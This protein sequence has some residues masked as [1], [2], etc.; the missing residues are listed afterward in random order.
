HACHGR[1]RQVEV[2]RDAIL[3]LLAED[4]TLEPRDVIVMCPDVEAFAPLVHATFGAG[5]VV[6]DDEAAPSGDR[7]PDLRVRLADRSLRQTNPVLGVVA[8]LL[9]LADQR[10]TASQVL[11]LADREPVRRRFRFDDDEIARIEDWVADSGIRWGLDAPHRA[12]FKLDALDAGTWRAG[13]DRILVGVAMAE[14]GPRRFGPVLPLDDV[15]SGA[16]ELAGRL[17]ELLDRLRGAVDALSV[18]MPVAGWAEAIGAAADALCAAPPRETWQRAQLER[19]LDDAVREAAGST[20]PLALPEIRSLLADRLQGRP[21][22]ANF[23][24]GHLTVCT[25][26]PMRSVPHRVVCLLGLDDGAFPR[27]TA[28]DGDDLV[29]D[30]PRL[31]DRDPR[32]EDRQMLLDALLAASDRLVVTYSGRDERTNTPRPPAVPVGE[33]L[34]MVDATVRVPGDG[35]RARDQVVVEHPLQPFDR[36]SFEPGRL[37]PG[38]PWSFDRVMLAGARALEGERAPARPFLAGP[39]PAEAA[40]LVALEDLVRFAEHPVKAF[41]RGRLG[42]RVGRRDDETEDALPVQLDGLQEW[43]VGRRLLEARLAGTP[44]DAGVEAEIARGTLPPG[45]L[46]LPVIEKVRPVVEAIAAQAEA[47]LGPPGDPDP[48]DVR[49]ELPGGRSLRGTVPGLRGDVLAAVIYSRVSARHRL[50]MWVRWLALT[51]ARPERPVSALVI[52]RAEARESVV[53]LARIP[54]LAPDPE[55]RRATALA[56]LTTLVDLFD[57]GMREPLPIACLSSAAYANAAAR[58]LNAEA[59]GRN[60]WKSD[61]FD[62][63]DRDLEHQ[64]VH[65]GVLDFTELLEQLPRD[66]ERGDGWDETEPS[67]FGR[68]ARRLWAPLLAIEK[69]ED[70]S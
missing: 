61:R 32:T 65:G 54:P 2:V 36:R 14:A 10:L 31:G 62:K 66:D 63:E 46:A 51:A 53:T 8:R 15:E 12:P 58:N 18:P 45:R 34:D 44:L 30:D 23:R 1:A 25:L 13:L 20:A 11:D 3:H 38:R 50:A 26:V 6:E 43:G 24:T 47:A 42:V 48:V 21:T 68:Y 64:L 27:R 17:A 40:P 35:A 5:E 29:L 22:R 69:V 60:V 39:L 16:I 70:R 41:L 49:V 52:G 19:L 55:G 67:R 7:P 37:I 9:E 57:R 59:A 4:T 28:R 56:Q 33:L